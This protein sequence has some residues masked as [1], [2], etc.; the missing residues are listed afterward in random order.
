M[1]GAGAAPAALLP[2]WGTAMVEGCL[3]LPCRACGQPLKSPALSRPSL[4]GNC[5][6]DPTLTV[7][8]QIFPGVFLCIML[9]IRNLRRLL[10]HM[11]EQILK[12][13]GMESKFF[14]V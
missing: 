13:I 11:A 9:I 10:T 6:K 14:I 3:A 7:C 5:V 2:G 4:A 12:Q 8:L 1:P